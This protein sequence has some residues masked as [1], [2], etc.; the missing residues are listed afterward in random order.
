MRLE[1]LF[2]LLF[3][4]IIMN[5]SCNNCEGF[6]AKK[7]KKSTVKNKKTKDEGAKDEEAKDEEAK[8]EGAKDESKIGNKQDIMVNTFNTLK[9]KIITFMEKWEEIRGL[10]NE[11]NQKLIDT[12]IPFKMKLASQKRFE[13]IEKNRGDFEKTKINLMG[14]F[15]HKRQLED[16][17]Y[18]RTKMNTWEFYHV[19]TEKIEHL[20]KRDIDKFKLTSKHIDLWLEFMDKIWIPFFRQELINFNNYKDDKMR[21]VGVNKEENAKM[22]KSKGITQIATTPAINTKVDMDNV[23]PNVEMREDNKYTTFKSKNKVIKM[24]EEEYIKGGDMETGGPKPLKQLDPNFSYYGWTYMPPQTWSVPQ[25]KPPICLGETEKVLEYP[26]IGYPIESLN[27]EPELTEKYKLEQ[28]GKG[29]YIQEG[30]PEYPKYTSEYYNMHK[31]DNVI[32]NI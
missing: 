26:T 22:L 29:V 6:V 21:G 32:K 15:S 17:N 30:Q 24:S 20:E 2:I 9:G 12:S 27:W 10:H 16:L 8:D 13:N 14:I 11:Y 3:I 1:Y 23:S 28:M 4:L 19:K 25:R 5:K 18:R 7:K 31:S